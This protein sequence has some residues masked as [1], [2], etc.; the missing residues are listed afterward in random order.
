[1]TE[2][3][4]HKYSFQAEVKQILDIVIHSLYT[5]REIFIREL[6]SN[7]ADALEKVRY[8]KVTNPQITDPD[9]PLEIRLEVDEI[10]KTITITDTGIGMNEQ[11]VVEN[12]GTIAHSGTREFLEKLKEGSQDLR[13]IGQFGVGFYSSFM[14]AKKIRVL[15]RSFRPDD[16]GVEWTSEG[17]GEFSVRLVEH[18]NRGT[19][20][21]LNLRDDAAEFASK[22]WITRIIKEYSNFVPFPLF[23]QGE[24]LN[25]IQAIWTRNKNEV[26]EDE[27][28]EFY[29]FVAK[30]YDEPLYRLHYTADA[31]LQINALLFVPDD[32]FERLGLGKLEP[33]VN[34]Y[35]RRVLI[36]AHSDV[37]LPEWMR[38]VKG[39]VESED[40]PLNISR[41]TLQDNALVRKLGR[42]ITSR[43]LKFLAEQAES[44][45]E[46]YA[47]FWERFGMF[48]KEGVAHDTENRKELVKL[49]RFESSKTEPGKL[50]SLPDYF[51]RMAV[52]QEFIYYLNGPDRETIEA[53]PYVEIFRQ[54]GIEVLYVHHAVDEFVLSWVDEFEGKKIK[55]GDQSDLE[56][57]DSREE[58]QAEEELSLD[59]IESLSGWLKSILGDRVT[60]VRASKRLV[61]SPALILSSDSRFSATLQRVIHNMNEEAPEVKDLI[62]EFNPSHPILKQIFK[63]RA[64]SANEEGLKDF[65]EQLFD[66]AMIAAG[67]LK[68]SSSMVQRSYRILE[69]ALR[70]T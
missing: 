51:S 54:K 48:L 4:A 40:L 53:G 61:E 52:G 14:A 39:V 2:S 30:A 60:S 59:E 57:P 21:I 50:T 35:C 46:T 58:S 44:N 33:G 37:L 49:L 56:L 3:T 65:A 47:R 24:K 9:L 43:F 1:M 5:N 11:E 28:K 18:L 67:L 16:A 20:I 55:S 32:H 15:T 27:Y 10:A 25:T 29:K 7:A 13:L 22:D 23:L 62:L 34:L 41:E 63:M 66:T 70:A 36:Q 6:I 42:A 19:K 38:F 26:T 12:L 31:P 17:D 64:A 68:D 69:R 45:P 8:E